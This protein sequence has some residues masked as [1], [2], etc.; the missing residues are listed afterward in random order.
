ME[1]CN[2]KEYFLNFVSRIYLEVEIVKLVYAVR[3]YLIG[4]FKFF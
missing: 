1:I 2:I 3:N 4:D